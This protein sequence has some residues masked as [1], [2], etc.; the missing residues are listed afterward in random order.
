MLAEYGT[1]RFGQVAKDALALAVEGFASYQLFCQTLATP[2][3]VANLKKYPASARVF[4]PD[5]VPPKLGCIFRQPDLGHTL[6]LMVQAEEKALDCGKSREVAIQAARDVFYKGN[7]ARRMV[8]AL[9]ALGGLYTLDDFAEYSSSLEEP[10]STTY[11]GYEIYTNRTW[12]QGIVL[13]Q[14]LNILES[15]DRASLGHNRSQAMHLQVE[16]LK[17]AFADRERYAGDPSFVDVPVEGLLSKRYA[18]LR[19]S[20]LNTDTAQAT[21]PPGDPRRMRAV[22]DGQPAFERSLTPHPPSDPDGTTHLAVVD[23]FGNMEPLPAHSPACRKEWSW[24][25][26]AS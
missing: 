18:A 16:A 9:Q 14:T 12:T 15:Y 24:A 22:A 4:L 13:L 2:E 10:I 11:R 7:I 20:I 25:T 19:R 6:S 5:G 17:L 1:M 26:Q 8:D 3:R 23:V 21:Y